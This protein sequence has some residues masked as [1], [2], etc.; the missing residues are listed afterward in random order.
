MVQL[1]VDCY[2]KEA[3]IFRKYC[4]SKAKSIP[5]KKLHKL[6]KPC[7]KTASLSFSSKP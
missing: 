7:C 5:R 1:E 2:I 4:K 3:K 6:R